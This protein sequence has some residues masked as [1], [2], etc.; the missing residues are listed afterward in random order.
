MSNKRHARSIQFCL[1][2]QIPVSELPL[3]ITVVVDNRSFQGIC[4]LSLLSTFIQ[5]HP[6]LTPIHVCLLTL[7][8]KEVK[9]NKES[10]QSNYGI[11]F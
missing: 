2:T 8:K 9:I 7:S 5:T 6:T 10:I 1:W 11:S 4:L 3:V